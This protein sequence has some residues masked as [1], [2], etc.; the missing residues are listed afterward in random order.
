MVRGSGGSA[1]DSGFPSSG[2]VIE[3]ALARREITFE[4]VSDGVCT[5]AEGCQMF[6]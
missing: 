3:C 5:S 4:V 1:R 6:S 2:G